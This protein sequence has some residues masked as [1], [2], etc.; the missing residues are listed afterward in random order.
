MPPGPYKGSFIQ[1]AVSQWR[2]PQSCE[3]WE[4]IGD[5]KAAP[6]CKTL[7]RLNRH[8]SAIA[9]ANGALSRWW[10]VCLPTIPSTEGLKKMKRG[11][12]NKQNPDKLGM[13]QAA[14][15][16]MRVVS[17]LKEVVV[18]AKSSE[19]PYYWRIAH[20]YMYSF[21]IN[22]DVLEKEGVYF[23]SCK[24]SEEKVTPGKVA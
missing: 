12:R 7:Q 14:E 16:R 21:S 4:V 1:E 6:A 5:Q 20:V 22:P 3:H 15:R 23:S 10:K 2:S 18:I 24:T 19:H 9:G 11:L 8:S 13:P 17:L